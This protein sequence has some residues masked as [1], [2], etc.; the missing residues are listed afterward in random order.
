[1][2][3]IDEL[4]TEVASLRRRVEAAEAMLAI[5]ELK[6]R[7]GELADQ[8]F[9]RGAVVDE[10][11]LD[12][13]ASQI[14]GLFTADAMW[15]GGPALGRAVGTEAIADRMRRPTLTFARHLFVKPRIAVDGGTARARWDILCPC[16][17][18]D[19]SSFW[20][21]GFEDDEYVRTDDGWLHSS[22]KLTT[23]FM[24][25]TDGGWGKIFV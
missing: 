20:M 14:A 5:Q 19:G 16:S 2:S 12:H 8:R 18:P 21:C 11:S 17:T 9:S 4:A 15:D 7:Y 3:T 13:I 22:M 25:R 10:V 24:T 23:V 6:A 1:M